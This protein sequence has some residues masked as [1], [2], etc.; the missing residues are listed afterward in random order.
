M[1][2]TKRKQVLEPVG[3]PAKRVKTRAKAGNKPQSGDTVRHALLSRLYPNL[4]TLR[5]YVLAKLPPASRLRRKKITSV[6][7]QDSNPD[8]SCPC[9]DI[10]L[11][12][13]RL[14]DTT[15]VGFFDKRP[16]KT[17]NRWEQW[18]NFSQRG[19]ESYVTLSDGSAGA[20]FSQREVCCRSEQ[21]AS[22]PPLMCATD[23]GLRRL[24]SLL[25]REEG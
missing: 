24:A 18:A 20:L 5:E 11:A 12:L 13:G 9:P 14:L 8:R 25:K 22:A 23:R 17:D 19:D 6:G 7:L 16:A 3:Q 21:L 4:R 15:I 1:D 2:G 10:E